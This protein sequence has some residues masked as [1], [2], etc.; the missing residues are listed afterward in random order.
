MEK[1]KSKKMT[2]DKL[3]I[4]V[5]RGFKETQIDIKTDLSNEFRTELKKVHDRLDDIDNRLGK[6]ENNHERRLE[7]L[8]DRIRIIF[9][10]LEKDLKIKLPKSF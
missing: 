4:M 2:I 3:A 10:V 5:A 9:T 1:N 7:N 6:I 8:E